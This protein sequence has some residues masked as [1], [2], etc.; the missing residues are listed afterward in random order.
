MKAGAR[1]F[2]SIARPLSAA[3]RS[4]PVSLARTGAE[5]AVRRVLRK[6]EPLPRIIPP[7][8]SPVMGR[9]RLLQRGILIL[10]LGLFCLIYGSLYAMVTPFILVPFFV[11]PL[12]LLFIVLWAMPNLKHPPTLW[13]R[14]L[15]YAFTASILVW[16]NYLAI[17]LPGLPWITVARATSIPFALLLVLCLKSQDFRTELKQ[18]LGAAP[19]LWRLVVAFAVIQMFSLALSAKP[20]FSVQKFVFAQITWTAMFFGAAYLFRKPGSVQRWAILLWAAAVFVCVIGVWESREQ[21]VLW[22]GHIPGFLKIEDPAVQRILAGAMRTYTIKYRIISTFTTPLGFGEFMALALPF[23]L[24]F[25]TGVYPVRVRIAAGLT[26]ILMIYGTLN[27]GARLGLVGVFLALVTHVFFVAITQWKR[28]RD[29]IFGPAVTLAYPAIFCVACAAVLFVGRLHNAIIG[30]GSQSS[31]NDARM[32]QI[33]LGMPKILHNPIGYGIGM[34]GETL[35]FMPFGVM[36]I[37]NYFLL[38]ALEYG[39]VGFL[40][41]YTMIGLGI[42]VA[43]RRAYVDVN[44]DRDSFFLPAITS[45][46]LNFLVV[47]TVFSEQDNHPLVFMMLGALA[48]LSYRA[49]M[50]PQ[51]ADPSPAPA[52]AKSRSLVPVT[53]AG[54]VR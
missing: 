48:A 2:A 8:V 26:A 9:G 44:N 16:P 42:F 35:G 7:F 13:L 18:S 28:R 32:A 14:G 17:A 33:N 12:V 3:W 10:G 36:T 24:R 4:R 11:P 40:I 30:D 51:R 29:S 23:I 25:S 39:V 5:W 37:D 34:G 47:K 31:S 22:A 54:G 53:L 52:S 45:A 46:L 43:G 49:S 38:V 27:S 50:A 20:M 41:Y 6:R 1:P 21:H 15:F 19:V